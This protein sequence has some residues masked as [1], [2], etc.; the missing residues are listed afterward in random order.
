MT[1]AGLRERLAGSDPEIELHTSVPAPP[2]A[3]SGWLYSVPTVPSGRVAVV[4]F[5]AEPE[6]MIDRAFVSES[7]TVS[8][9]CTMKLNVPV[10]VG[11]PEITPEVGS[12]VNGGGS[13]PALVDQVSAP[14]PPVACTGW[15]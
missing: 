13:V 12:M 4:M 2:V 6:M 15:L 3:E 9:A 1:P 14:V 10:V 7:D 11:A 5:G 8:T